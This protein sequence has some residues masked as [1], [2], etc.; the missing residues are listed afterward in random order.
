MPTMPVAA[1]SQ[2]RE[3][4]PE[5]AV[6]LQTAAKLQM[7]ARLL[8]LPGE[9]GADGGEDAP[10][11]HHRLSLA[12]LLVAQ[13]EYMSPQALIV[14]NCKLHLRLSSYL[15]RLPAALLESGPA[16]AAAITSRSPAARVLL[17]H[18]AATLSE[19]PL[20][21]VRAA[22]SAADVLSDPACQAAAAQQ[23]EQLAAQ[24][25]ASA[26]PAGGSA[27]AGAAARSIQQLQQV[28]WRR[29]AEAGGALLVRQHRHSRVLQTGSDS[30]LMLAPEQ[31]AE[32]AAAVERACK[33]LVLL[34]PC[35]PKSLLAAA[36]AAASLQQAEQAADLCWRA[37]QQAQQAGS[38][39]WALRAAAAVLEGCSGLQLEGAAGQAALAVLRSAEP[40]LRQCRQGLP[41]A[42]WVP[43]EAEVRRA[44]RRACTAAAQ[45]LLLQQM[46]DSEARLVLAASFVKLGPSQ[47]LAGSGAGGSGDTSKP[48]SAGV[49][50]EQEQE[51]MGSGSLA[52]T[53]HLLLGT[54][55]AQQLSH[56]QQKQQQGHRQEHQDEEQKGCALA[57]RQSWEQEL[58][59]YA[60]AVRF[61]ISTLLEGVM[62]G[63]WG[64][65]GV[66]DEV[67]TT[68]L[69]RC[70][71]AALSARRCKALAVSNGRSRL[72]AKPQVGKPP[73]L[74]ACYSDALPLSLCDVC[75]AL[76]VADSWRGVCCPAFK[77]C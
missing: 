31:V 20:K 2:G 52:G 30:T 19:Q 63:L 13:L 56:E 5:T 24:A 55:L 39:L 70:L 57:P 51:E 59:R 73:M 21:V 1:A 23:L 18:A 27:V 43:V 50:Q 12:L 32:V 4:A 26:S 14:P 3:P 17:L 11:V 65:G 9:G 64:V 29:V 62:G 44:W 36:A 38:E 46:S 48:P 47:Q 15:A 10:Q 61:C 22:C 40:A 76:A 7:L 67:G 74:G 45:L 53:H 8:P 71:C 42:W 6:V 35:S 66:V 54:D 37:L 25:A 69:P 33:A 34:E 28:C 68:C 60:P 72:P 77:G 41:R 58:I 75:P 16:A 49:Q